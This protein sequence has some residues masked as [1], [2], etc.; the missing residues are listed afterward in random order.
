MKVWTINVFVFKQF[1]SFS[2]SVSYLF[3]N[4]KA[5]I[6]WKRVNKHLFEQIVNTFNRRF[7]LY[8][9]EFIHWFTC[10]KIY[11]MHPYS[12][13]IYFHETCRMSAIRDSKRGQEYSISIFFVFRVNFFLKLEKFSTS[14]INYL[15]FIGIIVS[16]RIPF[17][18]IFLE[19]LE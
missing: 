19:Y 1:L 12:N 5:S 4:Q 3:L 11:R 16:I 8:P 15:F 17:Y 2:V 14:G 9:R 10:L 7:L 13:Y 18:Y 6:R